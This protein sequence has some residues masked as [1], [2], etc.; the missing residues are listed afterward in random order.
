MVS[1][2]S[3]FLSGE[4][5]VEEDCDVDLPFSGLDD[6]LFVETVTD[7]THYHPLKQ[8]TNFQ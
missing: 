7:T 5:Q 2:Y 4:E 6:D 8:I 3:H 1:I